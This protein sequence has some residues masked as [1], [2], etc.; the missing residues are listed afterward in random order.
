MFVLLISWSS[1]YDNV[2]ENVDNETNDNKGH[3]VYN[4]DKNYDGWH[5]E[6]KIGIITKTENKWIYR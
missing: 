5:S 3:N 2:D 6:K 1:K 4:D